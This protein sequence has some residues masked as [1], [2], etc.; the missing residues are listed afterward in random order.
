VPDAATDVPFWGPDFA[1]LQREDPDIA[2]I[3]TGELD[4]LRGGLQLIASENLTSPAVLAALGL[5]AVEQVRRGL[6]RPA[7]LRRLLRGRQGRE[8]RIERAK[9]LFGTQADGSTVDIHAETPAATRRP[10]QLAVYAAAPAARDKGPRMS[11]PHGGH[12]TQ[13]ARR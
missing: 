3:V 9:Q 6:S 10:G 1:A 7:L 11:L 8:P 12:L 2:D 5:D 4:R 13:T